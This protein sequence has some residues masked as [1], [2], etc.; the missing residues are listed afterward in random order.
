MSFYQGEESAAA[1]PV[2]TDILNENAES[3][4]QVQQKRILVSVALVGSTSPG[5]C[6]FDINIGEKKVATCMNTRGGANLV[7]NR[8]DEQMIGKFVNSG[9]PVQMIVRTV[10]VG[11]AVRYQFRFKP[12]RTRRR[13]TWRRTTRR[14]Y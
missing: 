6:K 7:P 4:R 2:G 13:R 5:D 10:S 9:T 11:N 14:F 8:D 12:W 3:W 1:R